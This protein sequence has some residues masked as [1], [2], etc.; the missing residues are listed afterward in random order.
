MKKF[1]VLITA[2][3]CVT[4]CFLPVTG[5]DLNLPSDNQ[6]VEVL[7]HTIGLDG[8][9]TV[10]SK[11]TP[12]QVEQLKI[13][14]SDTQDALKTLKS[15]ASEA[16]KAQ[17]ELTLKNSYSQLREFNLISEDFTYEDFIELT[18]K[19]DH[20][21]DRIVELCNR[22]DRVIRPKGEENS[23]FAMATSFLGDGVG[24]NTFNIVDVFVPFITVTSFFLSALSDLSNVTSFFKLMFLISLVILVFP[25]HLIF[26]IFNVF[27]AVKGNHTIQ[28]LG[29]NSYGMD[30]NPG[31]FTDSIFIMTF[32]LWIEV[33]LEFCDEYPFYTSMWSYLGVG[34]WIGQNKL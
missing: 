19:E 16:E 5:S 22:F 8:K 4:T 9:E 10:K 12:S 30:T 7:C 24:V 28:V 27:S 17:A 23:S 29:N 2:I 1:I 25:M 11:L 18:T 6:K 33:P 26:G 21:A 31:N 13:T 14:I 15:S 20:R 34:L 3:I 32:G